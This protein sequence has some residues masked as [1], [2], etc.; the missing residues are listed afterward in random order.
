[1]SK[2]YTE[3]VVD[4]RVTVKVDIFPPPLLPTMDFLRLAL[5]DSVQLAIF[6][7][8]VEPYHSVGPFWFSLAASATR[9]GIPPKVPKRSQAHT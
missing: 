4:I 7:F 8:S 5:S 2:K 1:M 3:Q 6:G 9:P